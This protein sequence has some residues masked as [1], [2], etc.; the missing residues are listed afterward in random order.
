MSANKVVSLVLAGALLII[1]LVL[2]PS[3]P[4]PAIA[5]E[6]P[7]VIAYVRGSTYDI[8]VIS[9]DG[10]GDRVLWTA[11][12]PLTVWPAFDLAWRPGGRELAFSSQHEEACSWY[13]SD[14]YA[15]RYDG[16]G[17]RRVTNAPACAEL[18]ALPK[19]SVAVNVAK[20]TD[21]FVQVYVAG[22]PGIQTV[23]AS[24]TMLFD[25]VADLGPGVAQPVVGI[26]G[27]YR[28]FG[29][30][31]LPDVQPGATVTAGDLILAPYSGI[32]FFGTG[33]VSWN[34][35]GSA[36]AYGL[37][38]YSSISQIPAVPPY[39]SIGE[40]LPAVENA[41]P[42]LVAWG[43]T[44]ATKDQYLYYSLMSPMVD[45]I[46]GIY[47]NTVGD[48]SGGTKL[49]DIYNDDAQ[50]VW[51]IE[52]LP[53]A[54]GFLFTV[55]YWDD[56][57]FDFATN[58]FE[59]SFDPPAL[60]KLTHLTDDRTRALS[61]SPDGQQIAFEREADESHPTS[62]VWIV[63]RDGSDLHKLVDDADRPA[64]GRSP[65]PFDKHIYLPLLLR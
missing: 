51:D 49:V 25:N 15:I 53:D 30:A 62:S 13:Q 34:A 20:L 58:I 19:G 5:S 23:L 42:G 27:L 38:T 17:Y 50:A 60:T 24:G 41:S 33:K 37:R 39:G 7:G 26:N 56:D 28:V 40:S 63:N 65:A 18:A 2:V 35:D 31:P 10:T 54:S 14:I 3:R 8:H 57:I 46:D 22:A 11:P 47:L 32:R 9:P 55:R 61:V 52:W 16:T 21:D 4:A 48:M 6:D 12:H 36:L 1:A 59:Y 29:S 45:N 44:V 64:W 43:P